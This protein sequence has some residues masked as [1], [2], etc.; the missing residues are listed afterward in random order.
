MKTIHVSPQKM[1]QQDDWRPAIYLSGGAMLRGMGVDWSTLGDLAET[2]VEGW[3][4]SRNPAALN[5][6]PMVEITP[7]YRLRNI[8]PHWIETEP[9]HFSSPRI[10]GQPFC[11]EPLD[12][13]IR[14]VGRSCAAM[15]TA[16]HG[17]HPVDA[18][19]GIIRGLLQA[20]AVWVCFCLNQ[21]L[22]QDF[23]NESNS[24]GGLIRLGLKTIKGMPICPVPDVVQDLA[25]LYMGAYTRLVD[26]QQMLAS[27]RQQVKE[28]SATQLAGFDRLYRR[29]SKK[30]RGQFFNPRYIGD[31]LH[32]QQVEQE[33]L[34]IQLIEQYGFKS[35]TEL[36]VLNP[37]NGER[38]M[39]KKS[40]VLQIANISEHLSL[41]FPLQER[42]NETW[43]T[44][45]RALCQYDVLVS[46]FAENARVA[47]MDSLPGE[48]IYP[49]GQ[50]AALRFHK[51]PGAF[52]LLM[53]SRL[54]RMQLKRL[55]V[56]GG[57]RFIP[58]GQL[59]KTV[60]PEPD[61]T[62]AKFW[63]EKV[64][65]HHEKSRDAEKELNVILQQ[66]LPVFNAAHGISQSPIKPHAISRLPGKGDSGT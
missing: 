55:A 36:A 40:K 22:Y 33:Y 27:V 51:Y 24:I 34:R 56:N 3:R 16:S 11:V 61:P 58:L 49:S 29:Y 19:L 31:A 59:D 4:V 38:V 50:I 1:E 30:C 9:D 48:L 32:V 66:L 15:V 44:Q 64:V 52:A 6:D 18:N 5:Y 20:Q 47:Y 26:A 12:I 60:L 42:T 62:T 43:R 25:P 23:L 37:I 2:C 21:P 35:I 53:E 57:L 45:Y 54:V 17:R 14:K 7:V 63:H 41:K 8:Q 28:W 39:G 10:A 65:A 46:T 13:I